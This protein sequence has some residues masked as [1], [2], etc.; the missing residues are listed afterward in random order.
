[1]PILSTLCITRQ[2]DSLRLIGMRM[3][4]NTE[5]AGQLSRSSPELNCFRPHWEFSVVNNKKQPRGVSVTVII[6]DE[7]EWLLSLAGARAV[8]SSLIRKKMRHCLKTSPLDLSTFSRIP[9]HKFLNDPRGLCLELAL[10]E[11]K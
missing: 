8:I 11:S 1:M 10:H 2:L 5:Q 7:A 6:K 4:R 3:H 9:T